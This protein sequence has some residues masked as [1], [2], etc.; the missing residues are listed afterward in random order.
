M[1]RD[2]AYMKSLVTYVQLKKE[3]KEEWKNVLEAAKQGDINTFTIIKSYENHHT[4]IDEHGEIL[5]YRYQI[6]PDL[7]EKLAKTTG[8]LP[9]KGVN[10]GIRGNYPTRHYA[11]WHDYTKVPYVTSEYRKALLAKE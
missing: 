7:L 9:H 6:K 4:I 1:Q 5:G 8:D 2:I 10:A 11:V 3:R